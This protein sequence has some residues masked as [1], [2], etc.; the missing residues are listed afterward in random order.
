MALA[1]AAEGSGQSSPD[2]L[3]AAEAYAQGWSMESLAED[4]LDVY[5]RAIAAFDRGSR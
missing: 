2:A 5:Q 3:K 1:D 4:Y